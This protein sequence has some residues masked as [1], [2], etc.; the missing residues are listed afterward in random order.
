[1]SA[2]PDPLEAAE[3]AHRMAAVLVD[4]ARSEGADDPELTAR[5]VDLVA[6]VGLNTVAELWAHR[7][8]RT[9]PGALWRIYLVHEWVSR[10]P[11]EVG[12]AFTAGSAHAD[13]YRVIAGVAEPPGPED[14]R[15]LTTQILTGVF[16]GDMA[17]A[18]ERAAAFCH[19]TAAGMAD[20]S[21]EHTPRQGPDQD[22]GENHGAEVLSPIGAGSLLRRAGRLQS[23]AEDLQ[24][25]AALWRANDLL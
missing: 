22:T 10:Q 16:T 18:L 6:E 8:A 24:A 13:V 25:A 14:L 17:L 11:V 5:L 7:P 21:E 3:A 12:R 2:G 15:T 9:L 20:L 23:T 1:M 4:R 19:V